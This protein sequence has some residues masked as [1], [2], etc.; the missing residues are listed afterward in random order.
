MPKEEDA[1]FRTLV[2]MAPRLNATY[3]LVATTW[4]VSTEFGG[5]WEQAMAQP[6][7]FQTFAPSLIHSSTIDLSGLEG[8][9][10]NLTFFPQGFA[11]QEPGYV[12]FTSS[13]NQWIGVYDVVSTVPFT[14]Q[15]L[16]DMYTHNSAPGMAD[17]P[18]DWDRVCYGRQ[19]LMSG[20]AAG[21]GSPAIA[22]MMFTQNS[23]LFGSGEPSAVSKLYIYRVV[24]TVLPDNGA[25]LV[26]PGLR[27]AVGGII[28]PESELVHLDRMY[29]SYNALR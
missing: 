2:S 14:N 29:R 28:A 27:L 17:M 5:Q 21:A 10:K 24:T 18:G 20:M 26:L 9:G 16:A 25:L 1:E 4:N 11:L 12:F 13:V 6:N 22:N 15:Q 19:R 23:N 3:D 7:A 8:P